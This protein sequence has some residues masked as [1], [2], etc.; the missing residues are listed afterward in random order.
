MI[1][2]GGV[3]AL[4]SPSTA[5]S[6]S[7]RPPA[8]HL[9]GLRRA[10]TTV[11]L[12]LRLL[13]GMRAGAQERLWERRTTR[14]ALCGAFCDVQRPR[15]PVVLEADWNRNH[16]TRRRRRAPPTCSSSPATAPDDDDDDDEPP[17]PAAEPARRARVRRPFASW[18]SA[19]A[20]ELNAAAVA[21]V[22]T[23]ARRAGADPDDAP[24]A[25]DHRAR[26]FF[27]SKYLLATSPPARRLP[28][29]DSARAR[30]THVGWAGSSYNSIS[31]ASSS[32]VHG[33]ASRLGS[34]VAQRP[35][36]PPAVLP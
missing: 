36:T 9:R 35:C 12:G 23:D 14:V 8:P 32:G 27:K 1:F 18:P 17:E 15:L 31:L 3:F 5:T 22:A 33:E 4:A 28:G 6:A 26:F 21:A 20:A 29:T 30:V 34:M 2:V 16:R 10:V 19:A 24:G 7:A 13:H 25:A 11:H